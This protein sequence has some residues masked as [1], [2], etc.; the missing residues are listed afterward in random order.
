[1]C[2]FVVCS[3]LDFVSTETKVAEQR[4]ETRREKEYGD[5]SVRPKYMWLVI[6]R[7]SKIRLSLV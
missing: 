2:M 5:S 4:Y 6:F 3:P 7:Q 1:L